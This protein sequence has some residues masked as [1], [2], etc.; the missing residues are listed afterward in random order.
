MIS[1]RPRTALIATLTIISALL[2]A[3]SVSAQDPF[4]CA[5]V[6]IEGNSYDISALKKTYLVK[7]EPK[8]AHPNKLRVDYSLNPCQA[9][10][11][12]EG[13]TKT[14]CLS[15]TWVCQDTKVIFDDAEPKTVTLQ[16]IAGTAPATDKVPA[17]EV[18]PNVALAA[19]KDGVEELPWNL[20]LKGGLIA[21]QDQSAVITFICDASATDDNVSPTLTGYQNGVAAFSWKTKSACAKQIQLPTKEGMSG[22]GVFM[23]VLLSFGLVYIVLGAV[24]NHQVYGA[25]GLDLLPH[26]DFWRD[27]PSLVVDV[28]HHIWDSVTGRAR[29]GGYVSV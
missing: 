1:P 12:P 19:K 7:G 28:V 29:G 16:P 22:F 2:S 6:S 3:S 13:E 20:T 27:F 14:N 25:K 8:E 11:V 18:A 9:I 4:D 10:V 23:T 17:R 15:G 5:K 24:Y 21:G 26:R